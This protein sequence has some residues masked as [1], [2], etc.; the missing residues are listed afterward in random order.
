MLIIASL[1]ICRI[2]GPLLVLVVA[3]LR[4][5]LTITRTT[6]A[7][8]CAWVVVIVLAVLIVAT[9]LLEILTRL[10]RLRSGLKRCCAWAE[11][12]SLL[13]LLLLVV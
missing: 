11:A 9:V 2:V 12:T 4:A 7:A 5:V 6:I 1:T 10:K 3:T 13:R 8:L